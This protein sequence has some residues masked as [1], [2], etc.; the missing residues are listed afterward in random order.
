MG[1]NDEIAL[2]LQISSKR[3]SIS[4]EKGLVLKQNGDFESGS[5]GEPTDR[6]TEALTVEGGREGGGEGGVAGVGREG[7][8]PTHR[9]TYQWSGSWKGEDRQKR[10][11][12]GWPTAHDPHGTS[13]QLY[14]HLTICS[15]SLQQFISGRQC[16]KPPNPW[17]KT[18][19]K[20]FN[21]HVHKN[22][23]SKSQT[24]VHQRTLAES[25]HRH[26]LSLRLRRVHTVN[27]ACRISSSSQMELTQVSS[28]VMRSKPL[29]TC[30]CR[31]AQWHWR[32][33]SCGC[34]VARGDVDSASWELGWNN[35]S[36]KRRRWRQ[37]KIRLEQPPWSSSQT[38][39]TR[40]FPSSCVLYPVGT[41]PCRCRH[42]IQRPI[43]CGCQR[44]I[45]CCSGQKWRKRSMSTVNML[46]S[47]GATT[48][49]FVVDGTDAVSA[50]VTR[51]KASWN[52]KW[53]GYRWLKTW[54]FRATE[55]S[56]A[57][58]E[59]IRLGARRS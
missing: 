10:V 23:A 8:Q 11:K 2:I 16:Q 40:S 42:D 5:E 12:S 36:A 45:S 3:R 17:P 26:V 51:S 19:S 44:R 49:N 52:S 24:R 47:G 13:H 28:S 25:S 22:F 59:D 48:L 57:S 50:F 41:W 14:N 18:C 54:H 32:A 30:S 7:N 29:G 55:A 58:S 15:Q 34:N 38:K 37:E 6:P 35:T 1:E 31:L 27:W 46:T 4:I 39:L 20:N 33:K 43:S 9:P 21:C 56:D 53:H